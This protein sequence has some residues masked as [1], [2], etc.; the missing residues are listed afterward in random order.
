MMSMLHNSILP[1][2]TKSLLK[3]KKGRTS[4]NYRQ[5]H[6]IGLLFTMNSFFDFETIRSFENK[7]KKDG[8]EIFVLSYLPANVENF[9]FHYDFFTQKDFSFFG[10]IQAANIEKF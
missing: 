2:K 5:A 8:K 3:E 7:L 4:M 9:D 6:K 1:L 10:S